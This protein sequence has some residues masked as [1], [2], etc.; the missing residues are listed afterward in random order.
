MRGDLFYAHL[1][2]EGV[3]KNKLCIDALFGIRRY[4]LHA[5]VKLQD[6]TLFTA[7]WLIEDGQRVVFRQGTFQ[8]ERLTGGALFFP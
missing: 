1:W 4:S 8:K 7:S 5:E 3:L 2:S 6:S